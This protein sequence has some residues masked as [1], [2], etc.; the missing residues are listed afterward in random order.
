MQQKR[1]G[2]VV[3]R[4][5]DYERLFPGVREEKAIGEGS[6]CYLWSTSAP[7]AIARDN[8]EARIVIVLMDPA[9]RA[10]HQYLKSVSDGTVGHAFHKHLDLAMACDQKKL[11]VF[12]PF[13]DFGNYASQ[14]LRYRQ[15]FPDGQIHLSLYEE[16]QTDRGAW[17]A[18]VF[19]FLG[20][21]R[22]F[23]PGP[24]AVPSTPHVPRFARLNRALPLRQL[25]DMTKQILPKAMLEAARSKRSAREH[26]LPA[27]PLEDRARL[28]RYYREDILRLQD[29]IGRDL[30][31]W[32]Q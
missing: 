32:L 9:E 19:A 13:L 14:V 28:V 5:A 26:T 24:V 7:Y 17:L 23:R 29:L 12:H 21:N 25:K 22:D 11:G 8:P 3:S 10:F 20:V 4:R 1:F 30:S 16:T 15:C 6:V 27:L 18:R 2:G 31:T